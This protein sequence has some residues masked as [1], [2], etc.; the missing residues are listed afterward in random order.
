MNKHSS[1]FIAGCDNFLGRAIR[2]RLLVEGYDNCS[3]E[4]SAEVNLRDQNSVEEFFK[5]QKPEYV[6]LVAGKTGGIQANIQFPADL[7]RDNLLVQTHVLHSAYTHGVTKLLFLASSCSYPRGGPQP[8]KIADLM[9]GPLEPTNE[10]YATAKLAG[11]AMVRAYKQQ[12]DLDF[13]AGIPGNIFGP[14]ED[15]CPENAHVIP[16]LMFRMHEARCQQDSYLE[17]WGTGKP[18]RQYIYVDDVASGCVFVMKHYHDALPINIGGEVCVSIRDLA[19]KIQDIVGF[20]GELRFNDK[21]PDGMPLKALDS[22]PLLEM[23]WSPS[24]SLD[25]GLRDM[26]KWFKL[27]NRSRQFELQST[28]SLVM[29]STET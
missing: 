28:E 7:M 12:Y 4:I 15:C 17:V 2:R 10:A 5:E 22:T 3:D 27:M 16:S 19:F 11:L 23:G 1:I 6:F 24:T 9:S 18:L 26:Y 21:K 8:L 20:A 14:E 25:D 13:I 29:A